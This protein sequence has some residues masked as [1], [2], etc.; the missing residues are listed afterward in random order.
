MNDKIYLGRALKIWEQHVQWS[1][2]RRENLK[3]TKAP[4]LKDQREGG[5]DPG[6]GWQAMIKI[7]YNHCG[8]TGEQMWENR[9]EEL[10]ELSR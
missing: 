5:I 2:C 1:G 8:K 9:L 4:N 3:K 10:L 7:S 6:V